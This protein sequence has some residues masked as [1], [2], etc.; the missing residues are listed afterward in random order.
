[1]RFSSP[2]LLVVIVLSVGLLAGVQESSPSPGVIRGRIHDE[3]GQP[4]A[5]AVIHLRHRGSN[6]EYEVSTG[7]DGRFRQRNLSLGRYDLT[8]I[9]DGE[10]LWKFPFRLTLAQTSVQVELDI[11][12]LREAARTLS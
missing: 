4:L 11:G 1:M 8:V 9:R 10:T 12:K 7:Q 5:G 2:Q 6:G 3:Q